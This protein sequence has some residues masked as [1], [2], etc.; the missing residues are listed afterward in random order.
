MDFW[1]DES[2]PVPPKISVISWQQSL[3]TWFTTAQMSL[4]VRVTGS[5]ASY[6][7]M[8]KPQSISKTELKIKATQREKTIGCLESFFLFSNFFISKNLH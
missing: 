2:G 4:S 8:R 3:D 6:I 7:D 5:G 1:P